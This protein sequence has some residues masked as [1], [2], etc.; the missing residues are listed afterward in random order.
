LGVSRVDC[1]SKS[2]SEFLIV[3]RNVTH[4]THNFVPLSNWELELFETVIPD[5]MIGRWRY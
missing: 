5:L 2:H 3:L 4:T 1:K